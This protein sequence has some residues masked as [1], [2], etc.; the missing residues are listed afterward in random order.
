M[1]QLPEFQWGIDFYSLIFR[2][3]SLPQDYFVGI[4]LEAIRL[5]EI[6]SMTSVQK[7]IAACSIH[8]TAG[9]P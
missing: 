2:D 8:A 5:P 9:A 1:Q 6:I 4:N 3:Y 7:L